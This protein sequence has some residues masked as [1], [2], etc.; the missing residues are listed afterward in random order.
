MGEDRQRLFAWLRR[1]FTS[2]PPAAN[3]TQDAPQPE[4]GRPVSRFPSDVRTVPVAAQ[5]IAVSSRNES[6]RN[7][8]SDVKSMETGGG[9]WLFASDVAVTRSGGLLVRANAYTWRSQLN[10]PLFI[11]RRPDGSYWLNV[12]YDFQPQVW[13]ST[14]ETYVVISRIACEGTE[15]ASAIG[16]VGVDGSTACTLKAPPA[17][18]EGMPAMPRSPVLE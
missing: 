13:A 12:P 9:R 7:G 3:L 6:D 5:A 1:P 11:T 8:W 2:P 4:P 15:L 10:S 14:D 18:V 16:H 17:M